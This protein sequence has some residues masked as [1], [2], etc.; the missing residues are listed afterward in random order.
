MGIILEVKN[1]RKRFPVTKGLLLKTIGWV[2]AIAGV[3]FS[4]NDGECFGL[5]GESGCGKTTTAKTILRLEK[6]TDGLVLFRGKDVFTLPKTNLKQYRSS[7]Q[8][9]FQDPYSSLEPRMR[10]GSIISEPLQV[11]TSYPRE[12]LRKELMRSWTK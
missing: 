4:I 2:E 12:R 11:N 10:V 8:A 7:V 6:P 5:V 3:T 9:V 1:L